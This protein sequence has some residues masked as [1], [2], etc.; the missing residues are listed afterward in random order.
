MPGRAAQPSRI[1]LDRVQADGT[2]LPC[3]WIEPETGAERL[4]HAYHDRA[5]EAAGAVSIGDLEVDVQRGRIS[6]IEASRLGVNAFHT[7]D[8]PAAI[9]SSISF[10]GEDGR[11]GGTLAAKGD[12]LLARVHRSLEAKVALVDSGEREVTDCV[13]RLRGSSSA[14][15][16][17]RDALLS[18]AGRSQIE[19]LS[20]GT[21]AKHLSKRSLLS[22]LV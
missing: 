13:Y 6:R 4:D 22:V 11:L 7:T 21:G 8:F 3:R 16:R 2:W 20:R 18:S 15:K 17:V 9:G 1:R 10:H 14:I 12:L 5:V 19:A